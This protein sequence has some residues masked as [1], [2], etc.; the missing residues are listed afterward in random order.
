MVARVHAVGP[1]KTAKVEKTRAKLMMPLAVRP[2]GLEDPVDFEDSEAP[3]SL[4]NSER[5][6]SPEDL[7]GPER[8]RVWAG[9][10]ALFR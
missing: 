6:E 3:E 4:E 7:A 2:T 5:P 1:A 9:V 8:S 10:A